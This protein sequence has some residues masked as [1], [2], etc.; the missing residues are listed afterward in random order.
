MRRARIE[1]RR[2]LT[3]CLVAFF[4]VVLV[5]TAWLG[6][7]A[8]IT[9]RTV[10][11]LVSGFGPRWNVAER[12]QAYTHPLWMIVLAVPYYFTREAYFTT[13]AVM[14]AFSLLTVYAF[15]TRIA[16]S[17]ALAVIGGAALVLSKAFV[18]YSTSGLENSLTHA[19]L[20]FWLI[21][22]WRARPGQEVGEPTHERGLTAL[23]VLAG[24]AMLNR[25]DL[26]LLVGPGLIVC[27]WSAG[28]RRTRR[29]AAIG[30]APLIAWEVFSV[31]YYGFPF[32][33]TAYA[34]LPSNVGAST[35]VAQ[36]LLYLLDAFAIDPVT[37]LVIVIALAWVVSSRRRDE[38]PLAVG[39]A[40]YLLYI[41]RIGGDFM[42]G[43]FLTPPFLC[44]A[45]LLVHG[46]WRLPRTAA[47][48]AVG[49]LALLGIFATTRPPVTSGS[50]TY[51]LNA[52]DGLS[53]SGIA[54]ERVFY[55]RYTGLLRWSRERPLPWNDQ[56]KIGEQLRAA[57]RVT[58]ESS[59]GF[60][61]YYAGPAVHLVDELGL[62]DAFL[63]RRPATPGW[64]V[65][66]YQRPSPPGYI[67]S[68]ESG[69]NLLTDTQ[70]AYEY[71]RIRLITQGP[72]WTAR[73]WRAILALNGPR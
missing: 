61:G 13:Y 2:L 15:L 46:R 10:D 50:G 59:I 65:G 20:V 73:R 31:I 44:A 11:N 49:A 47:P 45:A 53:N 33:N 52:L 3:A 43:R 39:I 17:A 14:F 37:P 6:D 7:D 26:V 25:L 9:L 67:E 55:Y 29:A 18:D 4:F 16:S 22:Y 68:I 30:L 42:T 40:L 57:P 19:V 63:A 24:L 27:S 66:H 36:G 8:F 21:C 51:I 1:M 54:D 23:W 58:R 32:P 70:Q 71:E 5:R 64:R 48:L 56:V 38:V 12:V 69:K 41:V 28:W 62:A 35:L 34:K 60:T 72:L